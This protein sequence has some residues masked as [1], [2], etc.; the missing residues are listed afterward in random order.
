MQISNFIMI[1]AVVVSPLVAVQ[2]QKYI[3]RARE[4]YRRKFGI[5]QTLMATRQ[6]R[7]SLAHVQALNMIPL[8]FYGTKLY[9]FR[10]Q[11]RSEKDVVSAWKIYLDHLQQHFDDKSFEI[12]N[13]KREDLFTELLDTMSKSLNFNF[14]KVELKHHIY[15]PQAHTDEEMYQGLL[16]LSIIDI[17][18]GKK[19]VPIEIVSIPVEENDLKEQRNLHTKLTE[20][21][22]GKTSI[23]VLLKPTEN[24]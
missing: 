8:E 10:H 12:W 14:D 7:V 16:R 22:D 18:R 24:D 1:L 19:A 5:F 17:L 2:V 4:R 9:K 21:L 3:E 11:R 13:N 20:C 6:N 23:K 15:R